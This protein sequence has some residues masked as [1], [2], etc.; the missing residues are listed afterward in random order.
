MPN[1]GE[2]FIEWCYYD[3][4]AEKRGYAKIR[5]AVGR[6]DR[7][8]L[9]I[10]GEKCMKGLVAILF[11]LCLSV[12]AG[13]GLMGPDPYPGGGLKLGPDLDPITVSFRAPVG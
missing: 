9:I 1:V 2:G 11:V 7:G 10:D 4:A 6:N 8:S 3:E 12:S 13:G 5:S